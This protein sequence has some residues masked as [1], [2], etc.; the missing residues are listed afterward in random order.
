M[1]D[2]ERRCGKGSYELP[3]FSGWWVFVSASGERHFSHIRMTPEGRPELFRG[4]PNIR[5]AYAGEAWWPARIIGLDDTPG[6]TAAS[7]LDVVLQA[8]VR[9]VIAQEVSHYFPDRSPP[10]S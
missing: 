7:T 8:M 3:V 5:K 6:H 4:W 2:T 1:T 10:P 9:E